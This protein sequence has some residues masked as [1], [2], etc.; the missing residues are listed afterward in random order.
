MAEGKASGKKEIK[1]NRERTQFLKSIE[2]QQKKQINLR[3]K[4]TATK[5]EE[6][7]EDRREVRS[8]S[9]AE[10]EGEDLIQPPSSLPKNWGLKRGEFRAVVFKVGCL[11][12]REH[13]VPSA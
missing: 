7:R 1:D 13:R 10:M 5:K 11:E 8:F 12:P 4:D 9:V 6:G 3:S 2:K